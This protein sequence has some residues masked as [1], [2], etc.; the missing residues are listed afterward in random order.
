[1]RVG[2]WEDV[3]GIPYNVHRPEGRSDR[4][5]CLLLACFPCPL[6]LA[7]ESI[8]EQSEGL[9]SDGY[10]VRMLSLSVAVIMSWGSDRVGNVAT[11]PKE[12]DT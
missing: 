2:R 12:E 8:S 9:E 7:Q 11:K 5:G 4:R 6:N 3:E 1:M 10:K